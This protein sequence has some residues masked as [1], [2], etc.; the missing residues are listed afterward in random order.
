MDIKRLDFDLKYKPVRKHYNDAGIDVKTQED[1]IIE[2]GTT[3]TVRLGFGIVLPDGMVG[4]VFPRSGLSSK[5]LTTQLPPIDSGYRG[6][7]H[8]VMTLELKPD[9]QLA[10]GKNIIKQDDNT[11]LIK[12][13]T[14]IAQLC[15]MP[16]VLAD[17][18]PQLGEERGANAFGSSGMAD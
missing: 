1:I 8:A 17:L 10:D 11:Y 7:I 3:K 12:A 2:V 9:S 6:E 4:Y 14:R 13:G 5:G 16:V 15:I 18:K